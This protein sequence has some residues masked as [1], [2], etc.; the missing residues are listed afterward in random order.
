VF[1]PGKL[2]GY[3]VL[4]LFYGPPLGQV[5]IATLPNCATGQYNLQHANGE[6]SCMLCDTNTTSNGGSQ[7]ACTACPAG[8]V[9]VRGAAGCAP[10]ECVTGTTSAACIPYTNRTK[11]GD[12]ID[13]P[14]IS[15]PY[16]IRKGS[17]FTVSAANPGYAHAPSARWLVDGV[18][19][20]NTCTNSDKCTF[21]IPPDY[22]GSVLR[23]SL[24]KIFITMSSSVYSSPELSISLIP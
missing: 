17:T 20:F 22:N 11:L 1:E 16:V 8:T 7:T 13:S 4:T 21:T 15:G 18:Q 3:Q 5:V 24:G 14:S 10:P 9:S 2:Y 23:S 12:H 6:S 19:Q